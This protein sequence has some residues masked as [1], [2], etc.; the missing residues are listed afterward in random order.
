MFVN[1]NFYLKFK[2]RSRRDLTQC[3]PGSGLEFSDWL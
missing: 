2:P 1:L 3:Q